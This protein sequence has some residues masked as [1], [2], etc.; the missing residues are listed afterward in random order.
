MLQLPQRSSY[1]L[2][3]LIDAAVAFLPFNKQIPRKHVQ[4]LKVLLSTKQRLMLMLSVDIDQTFSD[5]PKHRHR[6]Q[7]TIHPAAAF[8]LRRQLASDHEHLLRRRM[9]AKPPEHFPYRM[10][11]RQI[12]HGFHLRFIAAISNH[13]CGAS[14]ADYK[15]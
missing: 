2:K 10:Y 8:A 11:S 6:Y 14:S 1:F 9:H 4:P 7:L 5:L 3:L 13:I 12:E 15:T